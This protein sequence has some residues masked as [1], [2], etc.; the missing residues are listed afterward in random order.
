MKSLIQKVILILLVT[1]FCSMFAYADT[2]NLSTYHT[3]SKGNY[4]LLRLPPLGASLNSSCDIGEFY[5]NPNGEL[6]YCD[7]DGSGNNTGIW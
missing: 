1:G 5:T 4:S 2:Y 7:D 6:Q 3:S